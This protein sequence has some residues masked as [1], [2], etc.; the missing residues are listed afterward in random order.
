MRLKFVIC[1]VMAPLLFVGAC[2]AQKNGSGRIAPDGSDIATT[3]VY[4]GQDTHG[5]GV[6]SVD[7]R[8]QNA[9]YTGNNS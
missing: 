7:E 9:Q 1:V 6:G 3:G 2:R 8:I 5:E 4:N